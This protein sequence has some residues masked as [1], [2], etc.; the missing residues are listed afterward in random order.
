MGMASTSVSETSIGST[1]G[2]TS[3]GESGDLSGST[4]GIAETGSP[5]D[6]VMLYDLYLVACTEGQ[7]DAAEAGFDPETPMCF[8]GMGTQETGGAIRKVDGGSLILQPPDGDESFLSGTF[9][10]PNEVTSETAARLRFEFACVQPN[11]TG[12]A[13]DFLQVLVY[14]PGANRPASTP[15]ERSATLGPAMS[16]DVPI[17]FGGPDDELVIAV[18]AGTGIPGQAIELRRPRIV[19]DVQ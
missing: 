17:Q 7:W 12:C 19:L 8:E 13:I 15:V 10:L 2:T 11:M 6:E 5:G 1:E 9:V 4:S 14:A 3:L 16:V 18:F